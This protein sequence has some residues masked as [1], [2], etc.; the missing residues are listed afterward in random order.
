[1]ERRTFLVATGF[2]IAAPL[3][4]CLSRTASEKDAE[5]DTSHIS[6]AVSE[7]PVNSGGLAEFDPEETYKDVDIGSR[8]GVA[9]DYRPHAV[10]IWNEAAEP[11][12]RLRITNSKEKTVVH[13]ETYA[14]PDD[15]ALSVSLVEPAEY[16]V[17]MG[18]PETEAT[19]TLRVPCYFFDCNVSFTRIGVFAEGDIRSSVLSTTASCPSFEC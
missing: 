5:N 2:S 10:V 13:H 11:E 16:I 6:D 15:T 19:H 8:E 7:Y 12:I 9:D 4:G 18:V 1:M 14:I 3:A 17:E